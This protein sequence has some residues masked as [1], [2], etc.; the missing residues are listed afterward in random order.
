MSNDNC[1][2]AINMFALLF[3]AISLIM[4]VQ[5]IDFST[6]CFTQK[7][8][9]KV[10]SAVLMFNIFQSQTHKLSLSFEKHENGSFFITFSKAQLRALIKYLP[11]F[12]FSVLVVCREKIHFSDKWIFLILPALF[13]S[14]SLIDLLCFERKTNV[15]HPTL[16]ITQKVIMATEYL[17][18]LVLFVLLF[19][20][21]SLKLDS[22]S[23]NI[24]YY[25]YSLGT[26][27]SLALTAPFLK[28]FIIFIHWYN[29]SNNQEQ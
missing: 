14:F 10:V 12:I 13:Y 20:A 24:C 8:I 27:S 6:D 29:N 25:L 23:D 15:Y 17:V 4:F 2:Q 18:V 21:E 19:S 3:G 5:R 1:N 28:W 7:T 26:L 9:L 22:N 16:T 11:L